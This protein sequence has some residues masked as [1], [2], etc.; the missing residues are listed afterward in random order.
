MLKTQ[1]I[2]PAR[3]GSTRLPNKIIKD[4][5]GKPLIVRT[6]EQ[7]A[8]ANIGEVI[9]ACDSEIT[10]NL[11]EE[12]GFKAIMTDP[13]LP[14]GSDRIYAAMIELE[15]QTDE[16][17]DIIINVQ[18]DEP[19]TPISLLTETVETFEKNKDIDVLTYVYEQTD[20]E[21]FHK[22]NIVKTVIDRNNRAL[23]F[24]RSLIP[25]GTDEILVHIGYYAYKRDAL[26]QFVKAGACEL[27]KMEKLEQLRGLDLGLKY[28]VGF[29]EGTPPEVDTPEDLE[30]VRKIFADMDSE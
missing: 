25:H 18:G 15:K 10:K 3:L 16:K 2:I 22:D 13:E 11:V 29:A 20:K 19:L 5:H 27:E 14:S 1:I 23:Y 6:C 12:Y 17:A 30:K 9:V 4:I 7:A 24:S 21:T 26:E 8:K 28:Y